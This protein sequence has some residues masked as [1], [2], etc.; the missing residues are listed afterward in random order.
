LGRVGVVSEGRIIESKN[1][2]TPIRPTPIRRYVSPGTGTDSSV[3][4]EESN[5]TQTSLAEVLGID[6]ALVTKILKGEREITVDLVAGTGKLMLRTHKDTGIA[7]I[8]V[9][10]WFGTYGATL[11]LTLP[12][13][14]FRRIVETPE[15]GL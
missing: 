5:M 4:F 12:E 11:I 10:R 2:D 6:N 13:K 7:D 3:P 14:A 15:G 1:A 9:D 8:F